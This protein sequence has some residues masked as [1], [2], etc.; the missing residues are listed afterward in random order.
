L[1]GG[2]LQKANQPELEHLSV[3]KKD[4]DRSGYTSAARNTKNLNPG[5]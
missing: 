5:E 4:G 2:V 3:A 1:S